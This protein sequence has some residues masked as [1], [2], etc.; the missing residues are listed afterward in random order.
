MMEIPVRE[1]SNEQWLEALDGGPHFDLA[2]STL[3]EI[4][5]RGLRYAL[6]KNIDREL[7]QVVE[8][9]AQD[10]IL[11]IMEK[12]DTF[13]GEARF[14]TWAQKVAIRVG[15]SELRRHRWRNV[16][17]DNITDREDGSVFIPLEMADE[18]P[19]PE[20]HVSQSGIFNLVARLMEEKLTPR[21]LE[22]MT[23]LM[24]EGLTVE[25]VSWRMNTNRNALY[26]LTHDARL[27]L[28]E[29]LAEAGF[30]PEEALSA[31]S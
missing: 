10:A 15:L 21:Q 11:K 4:L 17:L 2:I 14:T 7:D 12:K 8:D 13:R 31:F 23:M 30:T 27:R 1:W 26:K 20:R 19:S 22:A 3:R 16:S 28:K 24:V 6:S 18:R 25:E 29:G 9:F 5:V